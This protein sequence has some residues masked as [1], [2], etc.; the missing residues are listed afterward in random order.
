MN[1][2]QRLQKGLILGLLALAACSGGAGPERVSP[3]SYSIAWD[4]PSDTTNVTGYRIYYGTSPI[5]TGTAGS[6]DV[7]SVGT[8]S[9]SFEPSAHGIAAG[10]T[11]YVA[12]SSTGLNGLESPLSSEVSVMVE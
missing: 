8:T 5:G 9:V 10:A 2:A 4:V 12:V 1:L 11:L 3:A 7:P 6:L